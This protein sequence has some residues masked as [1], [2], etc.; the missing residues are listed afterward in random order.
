ML[1]TDMVSYALRGSGAVGARLLEHK[2]SDLC[3]SS[4]TLAKLHYGAEAKRSQKI[5][6]ALRAFTNDVAVLPFDAASAEHFGVV[7]AQLAARGQPIG[8]CDTL[9]AAHALSLGLT[10]VTNNVRHFNRVQGLEVENWA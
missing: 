10:L 9:V 6:R 1:D 2:P 4:I 5:R 7:A 3:M 8:I